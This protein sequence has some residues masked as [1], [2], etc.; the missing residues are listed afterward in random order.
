MAIRRHTATV[1]NNEELDLIVNNGDLEALRQTTERLGF[2]DEESALRFMLAV[3]SKAATRVLTVTDQ[4]GA[5]ISLNPG[6]DLLR[7]QT[8]SGS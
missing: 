3:L 5:K 6:P 1:L 4:N 8:Q 2:K 7:P